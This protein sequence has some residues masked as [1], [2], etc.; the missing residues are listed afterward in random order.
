MTI[1]VLCP[2]IRLP[3]TFFVLPMRKKIAA[4]ATATGWITATLLL[5][6]CTVCHG[7]E[8]SREAAF[9]DQLTPLLRTYCFDCHGA[10][11]GEGDVKLESYQSLQALTADRKEWLRALKQVQLGSMPPADAEQLYDAL[12]I[13][14]RQQHQRVAAG[15][16]GADM[17]VA[18]ENDGPVT[19]MLRS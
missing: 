17:K 3:M 16:F 11:E 14:V 1:P 5:S 15:R 10:E 4:I 2:A 7:D 9:R 6:V 19:F 8:A 13:Y 12:L 18:L